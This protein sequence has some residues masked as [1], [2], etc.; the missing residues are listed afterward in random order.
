MLLTVADA[1]AQDTP[2]A[3]EET[4][5]DTA[6]KSKSGG[7]SKKKESKKKTFMGWRY[8][9]YVT[10]GGG[11]QINASNLSVTAGAD[12][13]IKYWKKKWTGK[14]YLG[15]SYTTGDSLNGYDV[16]LGDQTG[17]RLKYWGLTG[18]LE[19]FYNGYTYADGSGTDLAPSVGFDVPIQLTLGPKKYYV[20]GGVTPSFL[21]NEQRHADNVPLGDEFEWNVGVG[22]NYKGVNLQAAYAQRITAAGTVVTPTISLQIASLGINVD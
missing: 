4:A 1:L 7:S 21:L 8:E 5:H 19:A 9:P 15:G 13:G 17:A 18:G 14:V 2:V 22:V 3:V 20:Y 11:V 12:A 16:H 10:P 6:D